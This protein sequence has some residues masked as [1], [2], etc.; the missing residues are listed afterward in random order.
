MV[1]ARRRL[2]PVGLQ[3]RLAGWVALVTLACTAIAFVAVYGGTAADLRRQIDNDL[4]GDAG[5][6]ATTVSRLHASSPGEVADAAHDFVHDQPF[7]ATSRI[8]YVTIPGAAIVS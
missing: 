8:V 7:S 1:R 3:W 4:R 2:R 6:L 5:E